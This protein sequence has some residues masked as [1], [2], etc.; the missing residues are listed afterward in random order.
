[1]E[2][3]SIENIFSNQ[4]EASLWFIWHCGGKVRIIVFYF[5]LFLVYFDE[6]PGSLQCN[7]FDQFQGTV[8]CNF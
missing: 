7:F 1:M 3:K 8:S 4:E 2:Y 5:G 6:S